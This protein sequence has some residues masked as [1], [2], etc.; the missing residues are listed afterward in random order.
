MREGIKLRVSASSFSLTL[1]PVGTSML[2][3]L[4]SKPFTLVIR[5]KTELQLE[6]FDF[7]IFV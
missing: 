3:F 7:H 1:I 5:E 4:S 6:W 2:R